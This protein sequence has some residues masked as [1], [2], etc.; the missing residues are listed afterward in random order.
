MFQTDKK[1]KKEKKRKFLLGFT[2]LEVLLAISLITVGILGVFILIQRTV[3]FTSVSSNRL[4]AA[5][6]AQ[7]G[8]EIVRNIR[9][10]N[11]LERENWKNGLGDGQ[12]QADY[13]NDQSLDVYNGSF[14]NISDGFYSYS[15]GFPTKF[16]RKITITT[17]STSSFE[18]LVEI[19]W[20]DRGNPYSFSVKEHL[21][22]WYIIGI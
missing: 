14:L 8:I 17:I 21:Y 1:V 5:Y 18:V 6:L 10:T 12:W 19:N 16:Q 2:L 4:I 13:T 7:E 9:D 22:N 11:W 15:P 3:A 20:Q